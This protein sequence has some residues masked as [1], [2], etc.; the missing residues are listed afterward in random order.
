[1]SPNTQAHE[2]SL[3]LED[4]FLRADTPAG[5]LIVPGVSMTA[6]ENGLTVLAP[7]SP[8]RV[9]E[10]SQLQRLQRVRDLSLPDG[11]PATAFRV[12]TS[13]HSTLI[14]IPE[15]RLAAGEPEALGAHLAL[16]A[17]TH[18]PPLPPGSVGDQSAGPT[19]GATRRS[20]QR[21]RHSKRRPGQGPRH[22]V[23]RRR[24]WS[25]QSIS[26]IAMVLVTALIAAVLFHQ[27]MAQANGDSNLLALASTVPIVAKDLPGTWVPMQSKVE[28]EVPLLQQSSTNQVGAN[29][30]SCIH[31]SASTVQDMLGIGPSIGSVE[32]DPV[33]L[34]N[35][36]AGGNPLD[37][38]WTPST[39]VQTLTM[40]L[41]TPEVASFP[42]IFA[43]T[44]FSTCYTTLVTQSVIAA[45][46]TEAKTGAGLYP[47]FS[48]KP[49]PFD[50]PSAVS[51][52]GWQI[53][54]EISLGRHPTSFSFDSVYLTDG[55]LEAVVTALSEAQAIPDSLFDGMV[56]T[57]AARLAVAAPQVHG[58]THL[59]PFSGKQTIGR[60]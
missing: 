40:G 26:A 8:P 29:F 28:D 42:A 12:V 30:V 18:A 57:T 45:I 49:L 58:K 41:P 19:T 22:S 52:S 33:P 14:L 51:V 24:I 38:T 48:S 53:S 44:P 59:V 55:H 43:E 20:G 16:L 39:M 47:D 56:H 6:D 9:V 31:L 2:P 32:D 25:L 50:V 35:G 21:P 36:P 23:S 34:V 3:R 11:R 4:I 7:G 1:M 17:A 46:T 54:M 27:S 5:P 10:W 60:S 13:D 15:E 37:G